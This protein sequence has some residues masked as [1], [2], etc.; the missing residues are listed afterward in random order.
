ME[1]LRFQILPTSPS[2]LLLLLKPGCCGEAVPRP[3]YV[4][5]CRFIL[6]PW[7]MNTL[8]A[9]CQR[10]EI[11]TVCV[12]CRHVVER[13]DDR[14]TK[15]TACTFRLE[16]GVAVC[17]RDSIYRCCCCCCSDEVRGFSQTHPSLI[18]LSERPCDVLV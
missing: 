13:R 18:Q 12:L 8:A 1:E 9:V 2:L 14:V 10:R 6:L 17:Y 15:L 16:T 11:S 4:S 3:L 7:P 5:V